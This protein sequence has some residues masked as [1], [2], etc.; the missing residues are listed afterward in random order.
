MKNVN[1]YI[2]FIFLFIAGALSSCLDDKT[3]YDINKLDAVVIDTTGNPEYQILQFETLKIEPNVQTKLDE[4]ELTYTWK[5][6][7][8][9]K[10]KRMI[11]IGKEKKL[12]YVV[13]IPISKI[14]E[15]YSL[16][17][18]VTDNTNG[19]DYIT[20]WK[21][22]VQNSLGQGLIVADSKDG[23]STDLNLI[24]GERVTQDFV[25]DQ[26]KVRYGIYSLF[27]DGSYIDGIVK[28]MRQTTIVRNLSLLALTDNSVVK[29]FTKDFVFGAMNDDMF[30][31]DNGT[32]SPGVTYQFNQ[33]DIYVERGRLYATWLAISSE[34][35]N[36]V[37]NAQYIPDVIAVNSYGDPRVAFTFYDEASGKFGYM[38]NLKATEINLFEETLDTE[39][40][41]ANVLNKLNVAANVNVNKEHIH[42]LKDK[43][44]GDFGIY[45]IDEGELGFG[46]PVLPRANKMIDISSAPEIANAVNFIICSDQKVIYYTV[47]H[48]VYAIIYSS[49][50][51][52]TEL[53]YT[54]TEEITTLQMFNEANYPIAGHDEDWQPLPFISTNNK[55]LVMSTYNGTEGKVLLIPI[56]NAA[57]GTL[58]KSKIEVINGFGKISAITPQL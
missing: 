56:Q 6:N 10:D 20:R 2:C 15:S 23:L 13:N 14:G 51:I 4:S 49:S 16:C 33:H 3:T 52:T 31:S 55:Q 53:R 5:L 41:P 26:T 9:A 1:L 21:L 43:I 22:T 42:I 40:N 34:F 12:E 35:G 18:V 37:D 46:I 24:M 28:Q 38:P 50:T 36:P 27:N 32:Y 19:L 45:I 44:S 25:Y 57:I 54:S 30:F 7:P 17:C 11:I 29:V 39:F 58:D 47:G 8:D 48:N